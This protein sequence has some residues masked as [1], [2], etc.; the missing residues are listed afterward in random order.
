MCEISLRSAY[1]PASSVISTTD[2]RHVT[3]QHKP[4]P[5]PLIR[6]PTTFLPSLP[7]P[8]TTP[9]TLKIPN[10]RPLDVETQLLMSSLVTT[11]VAQSITSVR[12]ISSRPLTIATTRYN[13]HSAS[14]RRIRIHIHIDKHAYKRRR[15]C[16]CRTY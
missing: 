14:I 5:T 15:R 9:Y 16:R 12:F 4:V 2:I 6:S 8:S 13:L 3:F 11:K 1:H 10:T 7:F